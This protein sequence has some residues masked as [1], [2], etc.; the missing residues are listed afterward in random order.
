MIRRVAS[1][2]WAKSPS[3]AAEVGVGG[4]IASLSLQQV[5]HLVSIAAG[6]AT[7]LFVI[8]GAL[9]KWRT[10][11]MAWKHDHGKNHPSPPVSH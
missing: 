9:L 1:L 6:V 2:I 8:P 4:T 7:V 3:F 10:T 5:N 11:W